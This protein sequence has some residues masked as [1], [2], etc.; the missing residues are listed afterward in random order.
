DCQRVLQAMILVADDGGQLEQIS[1][2]AGLSLNATAA[3]LARL[4][5]LSLIQIR[6]NLHEKWYALHPLTRH[7]LI[8]QA[9]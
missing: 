6:G 3:C 9:E 5:T 7:F 2:A 4:A 8:Q 1:A